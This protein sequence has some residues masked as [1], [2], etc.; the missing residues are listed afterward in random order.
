MKMHPMLDKVKDYLVPID[1][2]EGK[3][4]DCSY[5]MK[6]DGTLFFAEGY[7]HP[8]GMV[9]GNILY[10]P[11]AEGHSSYYGERYGSVNKK[12]VNGELVRIPHDEQFTRHFEIDPALSSLN[13]DLPPF[14]QYR[15][16]YPI[17]SFAGYFD[18]RHSLNVACAKH[19]EVESA[20]SKVEKAMGV[21]RNR[22][23]VTGSLSFGIFDEVHDDIDLVFYGTVD[24]NLEVLRKID[25]LVK[26]EENK[27]F[28]FGRWWPIRFYLD[29][30]MICSF[31]CY[32]DPDQVALSDFEIEILEDGV[33][34]A[35]TVSDH[36][37]GLYMP[38]VLKL[39]NAKI[40]SYG[41][42]DLTMV[43]YNGLVR[44]EYRKGDRLKFRGKRVRLKIGSGPLKGEREAALIT[45]Y[46][47]IE[48]E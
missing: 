22:L 31:F 29:K 1:H 26:N 21:P 36:S 20:I 28:E 35:G 23:G 37:H 7:W 12:F 39:E 24:E 8:A 47:D 5:F 42:G 41:P 13:T 3:V 9:M 17:E 48:K 45:F 44:G 16:A 10:Y 4:V 34:G 27:V 25:D 15:V 18:H 43:I 46:K 19:A 32:S 33:V 30:M 40:G 14:A 38:P 6:H 11:D 2:L